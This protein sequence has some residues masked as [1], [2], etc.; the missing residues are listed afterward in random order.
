VKYLSGALLYGRLRVLP[1]NIRP[2]WKG[3]PE[4]NA[5]VYYEKAQFFKK[6]GQNFGF[7]QILEIS[8][9]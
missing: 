2:G 5:L 1:I 6:F 4:T 9:S 8:D 7:V 3:L